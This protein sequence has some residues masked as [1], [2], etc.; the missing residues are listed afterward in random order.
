MFKTFPQ[1]T[2]I[3]SIQGENSKA[4]DNN[5]VL[6]CSPQVVCPP[7]NPPQ[8]CSAGLVLQ[9]VCQEGPRSLDSEHTC[10]WRT[11]KWG[12]PELT[13]WVKAGHQTHP[14]HCPTCFGM[15][16]QAF[17]LKAHK[18]S[19]GESMS[20]SIRVC[21]ESKRALRTVSKIDSPKHEGQENWD[22]FIFHFPL[23]QGRCF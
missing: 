3:C 16:P 20:I 15:W 7:L 11:A 19:P 6:N 5:M 1:K 21:V 13:L 4:K 23:V 14:L 17:H 22:L 9:K 10:R 18:R 8:N 12:L 2:F